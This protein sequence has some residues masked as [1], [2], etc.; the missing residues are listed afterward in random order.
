MNRNV[1]P[2]RNG[3]DKREKRFPKI[4]VLIVLGVIILVAAVFYFLFRGNIDLSFQGPIRRLS[5]PTT[6]VG[7][8]KPLTSTGTT[9]TVEHGTTTFTSFPTPPPPKP[10]STDWQTFNNERCGFKLSYPPRFE[11]TQ[12]SYGVTEQDYP[13]PWEEPGF[14]QY[15][16]FGKDE[17]D[18]II[19]EITNDGRDPFHPIADVPNN[20]R[21]TSKTS[22][23]V[24]G[25]PAERIKTEL[26]SVWTTDRYVP[27]EKPCPMV[28]VN[29]R[30]G[31]RTY[32]FIEPCGQGNDGKYS[33]TGK[34]TYQREEFDKLVATF[35]FNL[36]DFSVV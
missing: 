10:I 23:L 36:I 18:F 3:E 31:S 15:F 5:A 8:P 27:L 9:I 34:Q 4:F 33:G 16:N 6:I 25:I 14:V 1:A 13:I 21:V 24:D 17:N 35:R 7:P 20:V 30:K 28:Q 26:I 11:V 12:I 22:M 2:D 29:F 32:S 19:L